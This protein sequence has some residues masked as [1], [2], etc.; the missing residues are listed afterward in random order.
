MTYAVREALDRYG[1]TGEPTG[2]FVRACLENN[3]TEAACRADASNV[4]CLDEIAK[5]IHNELPSRCHGSREI[6][7]AWIASHNL[8]PQMQEA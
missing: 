3:F 7:A 8:I 4:L 5:Y 6:V 2:S 1:R